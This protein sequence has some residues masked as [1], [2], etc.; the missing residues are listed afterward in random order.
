MQTANKTPHPYWFGL[1]VSKD[2][3]EAAGATILRTG[4][5]LRPEESSF[6]ICVEGVERFLEWARKTAETFDFGIA[7]ETT[8]VYSKRLCKLLLEVS[9]SLHV[10]ICNAAS[11]ALYAR[12]YTEAKSDRSDAAFI[13]RY[14][15]D[16][17]PA[18]TTL[19]NKTVEKLREAVRARDRLVDQRTELKN[20]LDSIEDGVTRRIQTEVIASQDRSIARLEARIMKIV[21]SDEAIRGE[22][23]RMATVP[24]VGRLSAAIIYAELGTLRN[25]TRKQIS[26]MSGVCPVN[27]LSGTSVHS[28]SMSRHGS[29]LLRK[30]LYLDS[31][32][33]INRIP[34]MAEFHQRMLCKPESSKMGAR[35]ACMRKL[36]LILHAM[37]VNE[38]DF[39]ANYK[40]EK[41][42]KN[43]QN[44]A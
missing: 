13:A 38:R 4:E 40:S 32:M 2:S 24:G 44:P 34:S 33:A 14:A 31:F 29:R 5:I 15:I 25:Y 6:P 21:D 12:S 16:R 17:N 11:V 23:D 30:I 8:G 28:H 22:I 35:C 39:D 1:D 7:M 37:V 42:V 18:A 27:R 10:V 26:A 20:S 9:P 41:I 43:L 19:P 36:L 3:F